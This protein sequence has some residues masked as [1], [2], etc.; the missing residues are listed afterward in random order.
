M[1][2]EKRSR[3]QQLELAVLGPT[4]PEIDVSPGL[5][6]SHNA[7]P[8]PQPHERTSEN[9]YRELLGLGCSKDY[10]LP[11]SLLSSHL[12]HYEL[13][14]WFPAWRVSCLCLNQALCV[15][16]SLLKPTKPV[17]VS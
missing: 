12:D 8:S 6:P 10:S 1:L 7:C 2:E 16:P 17:R 13:S 9:R 14:F 15:Q 3:H 4:N 5:A 11:S